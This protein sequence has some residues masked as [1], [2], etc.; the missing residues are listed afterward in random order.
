MSK[1]H[2]KSIIRQSI[3]ELDRFMA[4]GESRWEAKKALRTQAKKHGKKRWT[5]SDGKIHSYKTR[6]TYQEHVLNFVSWARS[7]EAIYDL[8]VL[9]SR[10]DELVSRFLRLE[11]KA[12]KSAWTLQTERSALRL[13]FQN[14]TLAREIK[15]AK[16]TR[17]SIKRSR[18]TVEH[19][20]HIQPAN[21]VSVFTFQ[22]AVGLRRS[23]LKR[24][25]VRNVYRDRQGQLVAYVRCGKGGKE[26][27]AEVLPGQEQHIL[28]MIAGRKPDE[29][30]FTHLPDTDLHALRR[31]YAQALYLY[32]AGPG[33]QLPPTD[34]RLRPT[35]Y[36]PDAI[37]RVSKTLGHNRREVVLNNY[38]R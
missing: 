19:D 35:D 3:E 13:F 27:E 37:D 11:I 38:L 30:I 29:R 15:I 31:E 20:R 21:W 4:I 32:Y 28:S 14:W 18:Y 6:Q 22:R 7:T 36:D 33:W 8:T 5:C 17:K 2:R 9:K 26:R 34:R 10:A 24:V 12:G 16:R 1:P 25:L 23:E